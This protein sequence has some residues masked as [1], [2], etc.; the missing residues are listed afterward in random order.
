[1]R[2]ITDKQIR[3]AIS[4]SAKSNETAYYVLTTLAKSGVRASE[5]INIRVQDLI[6]EE[7]QLIVRGK[8]NKIRNIDVPSSLLLLLINYAHRKKLKPSDRIFKM[9]R[10][11]VY[12][13]TKEFASINP[14]AFR[15]AYA[16]KLLRKTKNI[17]YVQKQLGHSSLTTTQIYLQFLEYKEEKKIVEEL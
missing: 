10:Q 8:G 17:R 7:S 14:H 3:D 15:H 9:T 4:E 12:Q 11:R 6:I 1:M 16:I 5:L 13:I 2:Y